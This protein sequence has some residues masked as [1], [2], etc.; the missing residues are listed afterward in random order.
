[1]HQ[2]QGEIAVWAAPVTPMT[3]T[4]PNVP[5]R[6][7]DR[8]KFLLAHLLTFSLGVLFLFYPFVGPGVRARLWI[9]FSSAQRLTRASESPGAPT[10]KAVLAGPG[11]DTAL[12]A[13]LDSRCAPW[14]SLG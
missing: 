6:Q 10:V 5:S 4:R 7:F 8:S 14:L 9:S 13:G 12:R 1:M 2:H 3:P 11:R